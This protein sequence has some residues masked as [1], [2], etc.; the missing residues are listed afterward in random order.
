MKSR[1]PLIHRALE[2]LRTPWGRQ[3]FIHH[4]MK[5]GQARLEPA[6]RR[7]DHLSTPR[8]TCPCCGWRGR[9]FRTAY[10]QTYRRRNAQCPK[11]LSLE[12]HRAYATFYRKVEFP[13]DPRTLYFAPELSL[14]DLFRQ[15][16]GVLVTTDLNG[17]RGVAIRSDMT[18]LPFPDETFDVVIQHHVLEHIPDDAKALSEVR[19]VLR[20]EGL[21]FIAVPLKESLERT[22]DWGFPE[23]TKEGHYR[24]Y[25]RDFGDLLRRAGFRWEARDLCAGV[26][27]EKL[28]EHGL[29][30]REVVFIARPNR[31]T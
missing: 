18:S 4:G 27:H 9:R 1:Q 30:E 13:K 24:D 10:F 29:M 11:C 31:E 15:R 3:A 22:L 16:S 2:L 14:R 23:P 7:L 6:L 25:G 12:R 17:S 19:R 8:V 5:L 21:L 20:P 26:A 28:R